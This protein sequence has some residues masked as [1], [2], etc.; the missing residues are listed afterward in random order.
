MSIAADIQEAVLS[1]DANTIFSRL[2][3]C[4]LTAASGRDFLINITS[5]FSLY[6]I[7]FCVNV[8]FCIMAEKHGSW[9]QDKIKDKHMRHKEESENKQE[10]GR[11]S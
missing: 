8:L 2:D 6:C 9:H 7:L 10:G 4:S 1:L 5:I 3:R 11:V